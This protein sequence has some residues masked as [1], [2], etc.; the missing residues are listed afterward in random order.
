[1]TKA[2][3]KN[4]RRTIS[5]SFGRYIAILL[6]IMLG[7]GFVA[8]LKMTRPVM[9]QVEADY[10]RENKMFDLRLLSTIGFDAEDAEAAAAVDGVECAAVSITQDFKTMLNG[11]E[12]VLRAQM[13]T[14]GVNLPVLMEGRL[15]QNGSECVVD[16]DRFGSSALGS[17]ILISDTND[18]DV[19]DVFAYNSYTIV[20]R[21]R[22]PLYFSADR[23][24]TTLGSGSLAGFV[25][26]PEQGFSAEYYTELYITAAETADPY[27]DAYDAIIDRI[28]DPVEAAV[29]ASVEERFD[30]LLSDAQAEISDARK[31]LNEEKADAEAELADAKQQL[32][33]ALR[34]LTDGESQL[35]DAAETIIDGREEIKK[36][37]ETLTAAKA[38]LDS[39]A[40][41]FSSWEEALDA[42]RAQVNAGQEELDAQKKAVSAQFGQAEAELNNSEAAYAAAQVRYE[43]Q[44]A[45]YEEALSQLEGDEA[46]AYAAENGPALE[47]AAA[48]LNAFRSQLDA[49]WASLEEQRSAAMAAFEEPQAQLDTASAQ[50][51][52]LEAGIAA[53]YSGKAQLDAADNELYWGYATYLE[54]VHKLEDGRKEYED[55]LREYEDGAQELNDKVRDAEQEI[56]DAEQELADTKAPVLYVLDRSS[57]SGYLTFEADSKIVENVAKV[58]PVFFFLIAALVC[59]TTMT[60]MIDDD[61]TQIGTMRALGYSRGTILGK[62]LIYSGSAALLGSVIGFFVCGWLFPKVIWTAYQM[63]YKIDGFVLIYNLPLFFLLLAAALLCSSGSTWLAC[64]MTMR[65]SPAELIRPKAPPAGKRIFL[66]RIGF[67]WQRLKFLRKVSLRNI[68]RY[69]KRMI[70]MI[71]GIAGCTALIVTAMGIHDSVA[72]ICEYQYGDIMK[73][74]LEITCADPVTDDDRQI[75]R[76]DLGSI[77]DVDCLVLRTSGDVIGSEA[78][79]SAYLIASDDASITEIID[80]H[81]NGRATAFPGLGQVVLTEKL[82]SQTG[83]SVG[84]TVEISISDTERASFR[85]SGSAENYVYSYI[86]MTGETYSQAFGK[87]YEPETLFLRLNPDADAHEAAV[88]AAACAPVLSVTVVKDFKQTVDNMMQSLNYVVALVLA[89]AAGLAFIVLFNLG[90]INIS[91]RVREIATLKVLGFHSRETGA[92]VF[93]ENLLLSVMGMIP[94]LPLGKLLHSFVIS[95]IKVDMVSFKPVV[96]KASYL[97]ALALVLLFTWLTD[98]LLRGKIR[99]I[100]MAESLKSVE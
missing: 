28:S 77:T 90:N 18:E 43:A 62:Y 83:L 32:D 41:G 85:I 21:V 80:L 33:D 96:T 88:Q 25:L 10:V 50:L 11:K 46:D 87:D 44:A 75:L 57:N 2:F 23:G 56:A 65:S 45:A 93:R 39:A 13:I 58:F 15:P 84:D 34:E 19:L 81:L 8:G 24:T 67:F 52:S 91:E 51:D 92:Y 60:R 86:Y 97:I 54:N 31:T 35:A 99:R 71:L 72:D 22:S 49:G 95:Q 82:M 66:E 61:R 76:Q 37:R 36:G 38:Q 53:Y 89:C 73:Y 16:A 14:E 9:A 59:S 5:G 12:A 6:I 7:V 55:G 94:G 48:E 17:S 78:T 69:K 100:N 42:G 20:G 3:R 63:L 26:L 47:A 27:T 4:L 64:R 70:M 1:M 98:L 79:K 74:D 29:T 40:A 68:F 30:R